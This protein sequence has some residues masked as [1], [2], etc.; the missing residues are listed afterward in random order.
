[1]PAD[2]HAQ[3]PTTCWSK[4]LAAREARSRREALG[5]LCETYWYPI[6][7]YLRRKGNP[8][9]DALDLTQ[10][11]FAR[12]IERDAILAA[13]DPDKGRFR[14][15]LLADCNR[16]LRDRFEHNHA[17]KRGGVRPALSLS[18]RD[19]EGR[20]LREPSHDNTPERLY[21]RAWALTLLNQVLDTLRTEYAD[22]GKLPLYDAL[23][24]VLT[25]G[26]S[27]LPHADIAARLNS[28]PGAVQV[29][30]SRLR[31]RY[32]ELLKQSIAATLVDPSEVEDEIRDLF[33][34]LA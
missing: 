14:S 8:P 12:L 20:Y 4:V 13:A 26:K 16:F 18:A 11:V 7:A 32:R 3:F 27:A 10:D 24:S 34:A 17:L 31:K 33:R 6:Y 30:A 19:A 2:S 21:D 1:M 23:K 28:T 25:E 5:V 9:E 15:F 22:A 29:A